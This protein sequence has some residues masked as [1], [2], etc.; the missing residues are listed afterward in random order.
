MR[1]G[2][3][4]AAATERRHRGLQRFGD[5]LHLGAGAQGT[6]ADHDQRAFGLAE[7]LCGALHGG[8]IDRR[9]G[10]RCERGK[11]D[12]R[13]AAPHVDRAFQ[14]H[15]AGAATAG[16]ADRLVH[17]RRRLVRRADARGHH[18]ESLR[19]A[20]DQR[21]AE[22][23]VGRGLLVPRVDHPQPVAGFV[24]GVEQMVVVHAG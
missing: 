2:D 9:D 20:G 5:G 16:D 13:R 22:R 18:G 1:G 21:G 17:Q 11:R 14:R 19:L 23:H 8:T 12:F 10:G 3:H 24:R 15:R 4:T 6:P 7:Q